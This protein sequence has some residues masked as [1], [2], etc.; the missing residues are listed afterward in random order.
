M[1]SVVAKARKKKPFDVEVFL[2]TVVGGRSVANYGKNQK[3]FY[4]G[5]PGDAVFYIQE[6]KVKV[7]VVSEQGTDAVVALLIDLNR[8]SIGWDSQRPADRRVS[9]G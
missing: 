8:N 6:G 7:C 9:S 4:Q 1:R 5:D 3:V 2:H